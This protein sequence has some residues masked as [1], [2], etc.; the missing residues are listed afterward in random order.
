MA[1]HRLSPAISS[2]GGQIARANAPCTFL[3]GCDPELLAGPRRR[4][5]VSIPVTTQ[6]HARDEDADPVQPFQK[7][8]GSTSPL[9]V[10]PGARLVVLRLAK[11]NAPSTPPSIKT[12]TCV[13]ARILMRSN[14]SVERRAAEIAGTALYSSSRP[15]QRV[16]RGPNFYRHH[17]PTL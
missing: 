11:R 15:L 4:V 10:A 16:V 14:F 7:L 2:E 1:P 8:I 5:N 12:S 13:R 17:A 9:R 6:L 3:R